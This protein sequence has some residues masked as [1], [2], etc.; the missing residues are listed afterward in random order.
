[1]CENHIPSPSVKDFFSF[2]RPAAWS[3]FG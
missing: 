1:L 2:L 3:I